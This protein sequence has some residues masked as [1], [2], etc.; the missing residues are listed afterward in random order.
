MEHGATPNASRREV[1]TDL[2]IDWPRSLKTAGF[3]PQRPQCL[4]SVRAI[5]LLD[6]GRGKP[7]LS[8]RL[9]SCV[10]RAAEFP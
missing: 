9:A 7:S 1:A 8:F 6:R 3:D 10:R 5:T 2:R 4:V